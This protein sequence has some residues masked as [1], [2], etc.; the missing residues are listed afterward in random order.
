MKAREIKW[1]GNV[2]GAH[3]DDFY[4]MSFR[5]MLWLAI[6]GSITTGSDVVYLWGLQPP[7]NRW[8]W[9]RLRAGLLPGLFK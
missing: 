4:K 9:H 6:G 8:T 2:H 5:D 7:A 1:T 3:G